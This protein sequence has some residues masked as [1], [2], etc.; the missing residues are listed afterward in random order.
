MV[1]SCPVLPQEAKTASPP[2]AA[3]SED[4]AR[5]ATSED[6][7]VDR[8]SPEVHSAFSDNPP[9][10]TE[11]NAAEKSESM[12]ISSG[13]VGEGSAEASKDESSESGNVVLEQQQSNE[14]PG[15]DSNAVDTVTQGRWE[16]KAC[17]QE[18]KGTKDSEEGEGVADRSV[19]EDE[20]QGTKQEGDSVAANK[21]AAH[22]MEP[23]AEC[24]ADSEQDATADDALDQLEDGEGNKVADEAVLGQAESGVQHDESSKVDGEA[25]LGQAESGVQ[26]DEG[27]KVDGEA[28]LGPAEGHMESDDGSKL[29]EEESSLAKAGDQHEMTRDDCQD[30]GEDVDQNKPEEIPSK[31][32]AE[33]VMDLD[34][35]PGEQEPDSEVPAEEEQKLSQEDDVA[36]ELD[37]EVVV[38]GKVCAQDDVGLELEDIQKPASENGKDISSQRDCVAAEKEEKGSEG[39]AHSPEEEELATE[40]DKEMVQQ[41]GDSTVPEEEEE[42]IPEEDKGIADRESRQ[43]DPEEPTPEE[44]TPEKPTPEAPASEKPASEKP[45]PEEQMEPS[46]ESGDKPA[47]EDKGEPSEGYSQAGT[48]KSSVADGHRKAEDASGG[49]ERPCSLDKSGDQGHMGPSAGSSHP[50]SGEPEESESARSDG[51]APERYRDKVS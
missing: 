31:I 33:E 37:Q 6:T 30:N 41:Q 26:H 49:D 29:V 27:S 1:F 14:V 38:E 20:S 42:V 21:E 39:K 8:S 40:T 50:Q 4:S 32:G 2:A 17:P 5:A 24:T 23:A 47:V 13:G 48:D 16:D 45:T 19:E 51:V 7:A 43:E 12:D 9:P 36:M 18:T 15:E 25:V 22:E 10:S 34:T 11:G 46:P 44:P 28:L 35:R 3:F